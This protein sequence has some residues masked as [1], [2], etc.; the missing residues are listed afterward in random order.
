MFYWYSLSAHVS[1]VVNPSGDVLVA[2]WKL[3]HEFSTCGSAAPFW[4]SCR[5]ALGDR[6]ANV[7]SGTF[8]FLLCVCC[9]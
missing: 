9:G 7:G 3:E 5:L 4:R 6:T 2:G 8:C 1:R